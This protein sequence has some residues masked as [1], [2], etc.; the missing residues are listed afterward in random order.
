MRVFVDTNH[1]SKA[2][3]PGGFHIPT[4]ENQR[5]CSRAIGVA[6]NTVLIAT[7]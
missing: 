7:S 1:V 2:Q 4:C 6:L 3:I 5:C